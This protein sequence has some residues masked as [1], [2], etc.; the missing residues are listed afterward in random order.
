MARC[1]LPNA[2]MASHQTSRTYHGILSSGRSIYRVPQTNIYTKDLETCG[3][4]PF[5]DK[6]PEQSPAKLLNQDSVEDL[7]HESCPSICHHDFARESPIMKW[8][9]LCHHNFL[10]TDDFFLF[11][12]AWDAHPYRNTH[13]QTHVLWL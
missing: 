9:A 7:P 6:T 13:I 5:S 3:D 12:L 2:G 8:G 4:H 11:S 10:F 1:V